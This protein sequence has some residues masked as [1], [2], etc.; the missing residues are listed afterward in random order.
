LIGWKKKFNLR[1]RYDPF[2]MAAS[3]QRL[4]REEAADDQFPQ[5]VANL[6]EFDQ[7]I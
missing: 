4:V 5:T 7:P 3:S 2:Q 1:G 6:T